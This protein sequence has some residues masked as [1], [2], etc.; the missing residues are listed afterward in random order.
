MTTTVDERVAGLAWK[1]AL[2]ASAPSSPQQVEEVLKKPEQLNQFIT[3]IAT[4]LTAP[5]LKILLTPQAQHRYTEAFAHWIELIDLVETTKPNISQTTV[6]QATV[7]IINH[8]PQLSAEFVASQMRKKLYLWRKQPINASA[9]PQRQLL[10]KWLEEHPENIEQLISAISQPLIAPELKLLLCTDIETEK[11]QQ[12]QQYWLNLLKGIQAR[13]NP[14]IIN[15]I[16]DNIRK[17]LQTLMPAEPPKHASLWRWQPLP[18]GEDYHPPSACQQL[19]LTDGFKLVAARVRGKKHKHDGRHCDDWFE[20][21]QS[22]RWGIVAVADGAGSKLFSRVGAKVACQTAVHYLVKHLAE[23]RLKSRAQWTSETFDRYPDYTFK[24]ADIEKTQVLLHEAMQAAYRGVEQACRQRDQLKYYYK[25]LGHRDITLS[26]LAT[27]LLLAVHQAVYVEDT[28][29]S[30]I[31]SCQV[32]DGMSSSIYKNKP[33]ASLLGELEKDSFGGE[34]VFLTTHEDH[35]TSEGL[36]LKTYPFFSPLNAFMI[37]TD[38]VFDDFF[39]PQQGMLQLL[40]NLILNGVMTPRAHAALSEAELNFIQQNK[41]H[42]FKLEDRLTATGPKPTP[43]C[44]IT[45]YSRLVNKSIAELIAAPEWL[46][47]GVP[48]EINTNGNTPEQR[49]QC[50]LDTYHVRGSFDDRTLVVL[51]RVTPC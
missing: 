33:E 19:E 37:M 38:G 26:D 50:W 1:L 28:L 20:I 47:A 3:L 27:T 24:Q 22:G 10:N 29:Y 9:N 45:D 46:T 35:L 7:F 48:A 17:W 25:A 39:P 34:T 42:Y 11:K 40:G 51:F 36:A 6:R 2:T 21:A 30:F 15:T 4:T 8:C 23:H 31:L 16:T 18:P 32:G 44:S 41:A 12:A 5:Q 13:Y 14:N 49:L 43:I